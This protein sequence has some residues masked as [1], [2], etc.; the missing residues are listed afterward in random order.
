MTATWFH[1]T[2]LA[3]NNADAATVI[4]PPQPLGSH[5]IAE[6]ALDPEIAFLNHGCF[7]ARPKRVMQAQAE[8]REAYEARPIEWLDR[9]RTA[10]I[11]EAARR[12]GEFIGA[13]PNNLGFVTNATGGVNAVLRSLTFKPGEELLTT[14]HVYNAVR[15]AMRFLARQA[16]A[17]YREIALPLPL[18]SPDEVI[19]AIANAVSDRTRLLV[20]DHI[21]SPTAV[22]FPI[23]SIVQLCRDRNVDVL[24]D[25]AHAPGMVPL[26]L[27]S[28]GAAYYT[29]NLH[30]WVCAPSGAAFLWV[31]PD[32][33]QHIHPTTIS[34]FYEQGFTREFEWQGTRDITPWL[35]A[36]A[37]LEYMAG[38]G[39]ERVMQ[40]NHELAVWVQA[41]LCDRWQV[42]PSTPLDGSMIGSMT[43]VLLPRQEVLHAK[44]A[45]PAKLHA[46]LYDQYRIEAPVVDWDGRW[47]I[48]PCCQIYNTPDQYEHLAQSVLELATT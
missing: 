24:V 30:K 32:R 23:E 35:S 11:G 38:F 47:W 31:R 22:L 44:F 15:Q 37:A 19:S 45:E 8:L 39:W 20:I 2:L 28:L 21:T 1:A 14:N 6:W 46:A 42:E 27:E 41:M 18:R 12:V 25:G 16:G 13:D 29:G 40:H 10:L 48:R 43:T 4:S 7:G 36:A 5:L 34:H 9:K 17:T 26:D 33:Q 3:M